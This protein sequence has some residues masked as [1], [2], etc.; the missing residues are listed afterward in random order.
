MDGFQIAERLSVQHPD[1]FKLLSS[2][3][4]PFCGHGD[5]KIDWRASGRVI[6]VDSEDNITGVRFAMA[7]RMPLNASCGLTKPYYQAIQHMLRLV[8]DPAYQIRLSLKAGECLILDNHRTLH[9]RTGMD[10][11]AGRTRRFRRFD[12]ERDAAQTQI[13]RLAKK[14]GMA[15]FPLP[16][17][18]H[19]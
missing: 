17:G 19:C 18:A 14:T 9:G 2:I 6:C 12:V 16:S 8:L 13:L 1:S 3:Q 5:S 4:Q 10:P 15:A 7:S 11:I